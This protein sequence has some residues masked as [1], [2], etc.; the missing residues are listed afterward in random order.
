MLLKKKN[1]IIIPK[2]SPPCSPKFHRLLSTFFRNQVNH[3]NILKEEI[4]QPKLPSIRKLIPKRIISIIPSSSSRGHFYIVFEQFS[5]ATSSNFSIG[6]GPTCLLQSSRV[7]ACFQNLLE[8]AGLTF[9]HYPSMRVF[10]EKRI[11]IA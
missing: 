6:N 9:S 5:V 7:I 4:F 2:S 8:K 11:L 10:A 3:S 1:L